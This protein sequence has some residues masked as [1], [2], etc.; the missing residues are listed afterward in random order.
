MKKLLLEL[1]GLSAVLLIC[2]LFLENRYKNYLTPVDFLFQRIYDAEAQKPKCLML[3]NSH[4]MQ[5][6]AGRKGYLNLGIG[7][8]DIYH[9]NLL[10]RK[11]LEKLGD[12]VKTVIFGVDLEVMGFQLAKAGEAYIDRQYYIQT[13]DIYDQS[14]SSILMAK[15]KFFRSNRDFAYLFASSSQGGNAQAGKAKAAANALP[16]LAASPDLCR[17]RALEA[18]LIKFDKK[19]VKEN[20]ETLAAMLALC[21]QR[22]IKAYVVVSPKRQCYYES[23]VAANVQLGL[24]AINKTVPAEILLNL[25]GSKAFG[26]SDFVDADHLSRQGLDKLGAAIEVRFGL[27]D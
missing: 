5:L 17:K 23:V 18:S 10:L 15:S 7:G 12:S 19:F 13:P 20:S 1:G 4:Y 24:E 9:Q 6:Y 25:N 22:N 8:Q 26:D 21:K 16:L 11:A 2:L 3:G 27:N 14:P